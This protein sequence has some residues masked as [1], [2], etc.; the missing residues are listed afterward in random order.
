MLIKRII[1]VLALSTLAACASGANS[2]NMTASIQ[3]N[4]VLPAGSSLREAI[5]IQKV[6]GGTKTNPLGTSQVSNTSFQTALKASLHQ[7]R[8]YAI[9]P[10]KFNLNA[11]LLKVN[12]PLMGLDMTVT[13]A[14]QYKIT[15]V[16]D[17]KLVFDET[18][19]SS[20]TA[21]FSDAAVGTERLRLATEGAIK[22][23]I[24]AFISTLA[25]KNI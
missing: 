14:V 24:T 19:R 1:A 18:I 22:N 21:G 15:R 23:N 4:L 5:S 7:N 3:P 2:S 6:S 11:M 12:Q 17:G 10:P 20:K 13:S 9:G 25:Q 8:L 16:S